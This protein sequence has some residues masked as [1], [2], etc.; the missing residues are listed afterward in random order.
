[1]SSYPI[2]DIEHL[3]KDTFM[4]RVDNPNIPSKSGQCF[5]VGLDS[6]GINREYS[7]YS[8]ADSMYLDFLIRSTEGGIISSALKKLNVGDSIE[9]DG[10]YGEFCLNEPINLEQEYLFIAT[11]TGIAP[12]H[13]FVETWPNLNYKLIHGIRYEEEQYHFEDYQKNLYFPCISKPSDGS[14]GFRVTDYLLKQ[15]LSTETLVYICGNR[16]MI[17]DVFN[18]LHSKGISGDRIITEVFF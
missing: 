11:G 17:V 2:I 14:A 15:D 16:K 10:A 13:S 9:I 3:T 7:M 8:S 5:N 4:I 1:M 6:L 12:F 18:I